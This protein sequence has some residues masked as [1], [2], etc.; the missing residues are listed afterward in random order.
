MVRLKTVNEELCSKLS[1]RSFPISDFIV[2]LLTVR[3]TVVSDVFSAK[4]SPSSRGHSLFTLPLLMILR[5]I[6]S[7]PVIF[8][9]EDTGG[10]DTELSIKSIARFVRNNTVTMLLYLNSYVVIW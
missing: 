10:S 1:P 8:T 2:Q 7:F 4:E 9:S 5:L 6:S 3:F